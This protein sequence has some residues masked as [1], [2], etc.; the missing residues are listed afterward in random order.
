MRCETY[1]FWV[2][3]HAVLRKELSRKFHGPTCRRF[4]QHV[5][6]FHDDWCGEYQGKTDAQ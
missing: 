4:P 5:T 1:K 6:C 2:K 3:N